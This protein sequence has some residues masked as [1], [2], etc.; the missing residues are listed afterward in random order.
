MAK[1]PVTPARKAPASPRS[2]GG[3]AR[4]IA[5]LIPQ[6]GDTA[7][8]KFGFVQSSVLTRWPEIVGPKL[9]KVTSPE[10]LRFA[11]GKQSDGV[12]HIAVSGAHAVI[13]QHAIPDIIARVNSFFGYSAVSGVRIKQGRAAAPAAAPRPK[14]PPVAE[15]TPE[16]ARTSPSMNAAGLKQVEDPELRTVLE[17]LAMSLA[18]RDAT[19]K[20][21]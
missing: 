11:R 15:V 7:F 3:D 21:R 16:M 20:T 6:V 5:D 1:A 14:A 10:S 4:A 19:E 9:A 18:R 8:R 17:A 2:R 13:V 12:L